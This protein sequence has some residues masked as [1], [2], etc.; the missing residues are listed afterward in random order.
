MTE[1][2]SLVLYNLFGMNGRHHLV[3]S[4]FKIISENKVRCWELFYKTVNIDENLTDD[5]DD[6]V[7][8]DNERERDIDVF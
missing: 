7:V 1:F 4:K 2:L 6:D 3:K 5:D 8:P